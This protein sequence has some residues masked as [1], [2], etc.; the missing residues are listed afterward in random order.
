MIINS[1]A[2]INQ[3]SNLSAKTEFFSNV[4]MNVI[5]NRSGTKITDLEG[6]Y[7]LVIICPVLNS[8][9]ACFCESMSCGGSENNTYSFCVSSENPYSDIGFVVRT[10]QS[11]YAFAQAEVSLSSD[12][13]QLIIDWTI[14]ITPK[15]E[16]SLAFSIIGLE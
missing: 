13:T 5:N 1:S 8:S 9:T 11:T 3:T 14:N 4:P 7:K 6:K 15:Y 10:A 2:C 16:T 12:G